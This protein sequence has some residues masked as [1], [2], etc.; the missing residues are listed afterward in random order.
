MHTVEWMIWSIVHLKC[1]CTP[2]TM[3]TLSFVSMFLF[4]AWKICRRIEYICIWKANTPHFADTGFWIYIF[5]TFHPQNVI[6]IQWCP[7]RMYWLIKKSTRSGVL[8]LSVCVL[9]HFLHISVIMSGMVFVCV[10]TS[11]CSQQQSQFH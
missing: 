3:R 9:V 1:A 2:N 7:I 10:W 11:T 5:R 6:H 8:G 4:E